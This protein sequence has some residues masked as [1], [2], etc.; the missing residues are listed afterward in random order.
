MRPARRRVRVCRH[1]GVSCGNRVDCS[2][3]GG[4]LFHDE[5]IFVSILDFFYTYDGFSRAA[6]TYGESYAI[7]PF[8]ALS[9]LA[10]TARKKLRGAILYPA[11]GCGIYMRD[12]IVG[13][14]KWI[15]AAG[16]PPQPCNDY[17]FIDGRHRHYK[18]AGG[19][20]EGQG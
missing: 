15:E 2:T 12:D 5:E 17:V 20:R 9:V 19:A 1:Q 13:A 4:R 8:Y 14:L 18:A 6:F 3:A 7:L 16:L 11:A 10:H